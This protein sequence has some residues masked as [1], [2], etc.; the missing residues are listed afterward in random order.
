MDRLLEEI[1]RSSTSDT[2]DR[3]LPIAAKA[4]LALL[5][6]NQ[7][8]TEEIQQL[9]QSRHELRVE[10]SEKQSQWNSERSEFQLDVRQL[11][12]EAEDLTQTLIRARHLHQQRLTE[13]NHLINNL[14]QREVFLIHR[15]QVLQ[16]ELLAVKDDNMDL[17][18]SLSG[19][20]NT[21]RLTAQQNNH[22]MTTS[23]QEVERANARSTHLQQQLD[24]LEETWILRNTETSLLY[25]IQHAQEEGIEQHRPVPDNS[26]S[27]AWPPPPPEAA[28]GE[29]VRETTSAACP[30]PGG[31]DPS[32]AEQ[33]DRDDWPRPPSP[34]HL[35]PGRQTA[36]CHLPGGAQRDT[37]HPQPRPRRAR[38]HTS[39][40]APP[41]PLP[42]PRR[43]SPSRIK[44]TM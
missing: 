14:R 9:R 19:V 11:T 23:H 6:E 15:T 39:V 26:A 25:E 33:E 18:E 2:A 24:L 13:D 29:E 4:G 3:L 36:A 38:R 42:R 22:Q 12:S 41:V 1:G 16:D 32:G 8:L 17:R 7:K 35:F 27:A 10:M 44:A 21:L 5:Q 30:L 20:H 40:G 37:W 34:A 43:L 28:S 31:T